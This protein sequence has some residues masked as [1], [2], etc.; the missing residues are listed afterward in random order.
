MMRK[1]LGSTML[2][3][4]AAVAVKDAKP[5]DEPDNQAVKVRP[6]DLPIY[7]TLHKSEA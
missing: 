6:T 2:F 5:K 3:S 1:A 7:T 4:A